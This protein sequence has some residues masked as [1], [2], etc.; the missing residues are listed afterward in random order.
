MRSRIEFLRECLKVL[1]LD[2]EG[3]LNSLAEQG[4]IPLEHYIDELA[5]D[6]DGIAAAAGDMR[7]K[8]E[9]DS[10]TCDSVRELNNYLGAISGKA[11]AHL[12]TAEALR[13]APEWQHVRRMAKDCLSLLG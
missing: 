8:G 11:N 10:A 2:A 13:T 4:C 12:W 1:S 9:T 3:Q 7:E 6:Y 5:L